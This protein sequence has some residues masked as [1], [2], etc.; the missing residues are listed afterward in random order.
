MHYS[1]FFFIIVIELIIP[2]ILNRRK[3]QLLLVLLS[4]I[5]I[6]YKFD[7]SIFIPDPWKYALEITS[8]IKEV[9][10]SLKYLEMVLVFFLSFYLFKDYFDRR[11][12]AFVSV[13][14]FFYALF[15]SISFL[16]ERLNVYY[17]LVYALLFAK[18]LY[19]V[20]SKFKERDKLYPVAVT[21]ISIFIGIRYYQYIFMADYS[22]IPEWEITNKERFIP[23][24]SIFNDE[25][26]RKF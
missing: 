24:Q 26:E 11:L 4:I 25:N 10:F 1:A 3:I 6:Q 22:E 15:S 8:L 18:L 17:D 21:F 12:V 23:Y 16:S 14:I 5:F 19:T 7:S 13:Q 20:I 2:F 9:G